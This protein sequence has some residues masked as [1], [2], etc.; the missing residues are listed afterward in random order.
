LPAV[1]QLK[2]SAKAC[3]EGSA[4]ICSLLQMG[5]AVVQARGSAASPDEALLCHSVGTVCPAQLQGMELS[6]AL[7][8]QKSMPLCEAREQICA[9]VASYGGEGQRQPCLAAFQELCAMQPRK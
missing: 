1:D 6:G 4:T 2:V 3:L 9:A 5:C 8:L 7:C